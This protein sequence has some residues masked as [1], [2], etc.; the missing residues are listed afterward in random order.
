MESG[1]RKRRQQER[2]TEKGTHKKNAVGGTGLASRYEQATLNY[3][4]TTIDD[5]A[6]LC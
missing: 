3:T 2:D 5:A 1:Q 4:Y 6:N